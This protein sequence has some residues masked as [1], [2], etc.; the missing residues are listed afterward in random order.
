[1]IV[2]K[3]WETVTNE[4]EP[5]YKTYRHDVK[6]QWKGYF[7]FGILPLYIKQIG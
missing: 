4:R 7:L 6:R 1:M 2:M 5:G 3:Y